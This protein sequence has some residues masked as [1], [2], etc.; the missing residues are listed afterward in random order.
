ML[1][2]G[3]KFSR[4]ETLARGER[5]RARRIAFV[6][7]QCVAAAAAALHNPVLFI[8]IITRCSSNYFSLS[9]SSLVLA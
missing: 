5:A 3:D 7:S 2:S 1:L 9:R 4:S 6:A 8:T